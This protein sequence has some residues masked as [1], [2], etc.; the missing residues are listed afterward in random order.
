M[1]ILTLEEYNEGRKL[2]SGNL[3][4]E[5]MVRDMLIYPT[6]MCYAEASSG[7]DLPASHWIGNSSPCCCL[8]LTIAASCKVAMRLDRHQS[9]LS[10]YS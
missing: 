10:S 3:N 6:G 8:D 1:A 5:L 7:S 2:L 4:F 9:L